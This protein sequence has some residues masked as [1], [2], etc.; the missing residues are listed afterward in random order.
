MSELPPGW[1][2]ARLEDLAAP[3]H[4][5]ITDGPFGSNLKSDHYTNSGARVIRLQNI[6]DGYF[7][8]E[9]SY[10]SLEHFYA[11]RAHEV[12]TGDLVV[13]SLGDA[14]PRASLVPLLADPAIVK[15]DCI[16]VRL[17][18]HV[19]HRWVLY[20]LMSPQTKGVAA[21]SIK[22]VG[23]PRLG[24]AQIR[25]LLVPVPPLTEQRRI[26]ATVDANLSLLDAALNLVEDTSQKASRL[27]LSTILTA[28]NGV[29]YSTARLGCLLREPLANGRS[30]PTR[31]GGF[32]VLRLSALASGSIQLSERKDGAW[33]REQALSFLVK[34]GD[35]LIS[36]GN[37]TLS[38]VGR[39]SAVLSDPGD[40]AFPDTM[41][42]VR[43]NEELLLLPYLALIWNSPMTRL[44]IE[45]NARTTAGIYKINQSIVENIELPLPSREDQAHVLQYVDGLSSQI[46]AAR[47][48]TLSVQTRARSLRSALFKEAFA[49]RLVP[50]D[51]N[52]EPASVLLERIKEER[53]AQPKVGRTPKKPNH[54]Q[55]SLL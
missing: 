48:S 19:D 54:E 44:Q 53:A 11:L 22:G 21:R 26:V 6:G 25:A 33:S 1:E 35:Y 10:I 14:P 45:K 29:E 20:T 30:V 15:A 13:A 42:R 32:P 47:R 24:M 38:L 46:A 37:G 3:M 51:P 2:W 16:R 55:G 31:I 5:A 9:R 52:E 36:R 41:I 18:S 23:R 7:R 39:G 49:G 4:R 27:E 40:V 8:D 34:S 12:R 17:S 28:L 43:P 50:Q